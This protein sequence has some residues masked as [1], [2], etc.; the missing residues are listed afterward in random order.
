MKL[1]TL[2]RDVK[3]LTGLKNALVSTKDEWIF[4]Q[5]ISD[6]SWVLLSSDEGR[7]NYIQ[8]NIDLLNSA[9]NGVSSYDRT[10]DNETRTKQRIRGNG[11][12]DL[13]DYMMKVEY[14]L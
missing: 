2:L 5:R 8:I 13:C 11:F 1:F 12:H 3:T 7:R 10:L 14:N 4:Y 9:I 6:S